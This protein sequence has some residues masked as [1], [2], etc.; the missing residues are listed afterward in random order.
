MEKIVL[1]GSDY[2]I[3]LFYSSRSK[4]TDTNGL[5]TELIEFKTVAGMD[6]GP[7]S[8]SSVITTLVSISRSRGE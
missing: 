1:A 5:P 7:S 4:V 6:S 2:F 8:V 3:G